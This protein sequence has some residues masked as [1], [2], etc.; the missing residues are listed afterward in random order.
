MRNLGVIDRIE[1]D[2]V[3]G[4]TVGLYNG[5]TIGTILNSGSIIDTPVIRAAGLANDGVIDAVLNTGLISGT[6]RGLY[7]TATIGRIVNSGTIAGLLALY[8]GGSIG[9]IDNSGL[10]TDSQG[11][12]SA[13]LNNGGQ[14]DV[15]RNS[16]TISGETYG[17]VNTGSLGRVT[18]LGLITGATAI[19]AAATG[20]L[21]PIDN[22]GMIAGNIDNQ[23][24]QALTITG[25]TFQTAGT[26]TGFGGGRGTISSLLA[27]VVFS[28]GVQLLDDDIVATG[29]VVSNAGATLGLL[30]SANITGG[31]SQTAGALYVLNGAQLVVSGAANLTGGAVVTQFDPTANYLANENA[32]TLVRGG[33]GSSYDGVNVD[34]GNIDGLALTSNAAGTDLVVT[35]R[36]TYIGGSL[37]SVANVDSL[38]ADYPVYIAATGTLGSLTNS[39]TLSGAIA[40]IYNAGTLGPITNSGIIAGNIDNRSTQALTITG[41]TF[42]TAGTL[43]GFGGARGTISSTS[44]D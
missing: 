38:A 32:G 31:Y 34:T 7:N 13:G 4:G 1:N 18:N 2:G 11:P 43:T 24:A 27:D 37:G 29:H 16:G 39:G 17:L 3:I 30:T 10:I 6:S 36:N 40:A 15:L 42:E 41:G 26:L 21:G 20:T 19:Y 14:L 25:G 33:V 8:N 9:T 5:G 23:T 44:A 35:A 22:G 28:S 12:A